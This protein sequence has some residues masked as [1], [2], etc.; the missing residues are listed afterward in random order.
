MSRT[1]GVTIAVG[2]EYEQL[3]AIAT[4]R[5]QEFT[6]CGVVI[7][8]EQ[9]FRASGLRHPSQLKFRLFDL[10]DAEQVVYFDADAFVMQRWN[11]DANRDPSMFQATRAFW[12]EPWVAR[13]GTLYGFED[14][15]VCSGVFLAQRTDHAAAFRLAERLQPASD[16][17]FGPLQRRRNR[18]QPGPAPVEDSHRLLGST[19]QLG[20]VWSRRSRRTGGRYP[21]CCFAAY[22]GARRSEILRTKV[23][24]VDL[25]AKTVTIHEKKRVRGKTT[26]R[27]VPLAPFLI[28]VLQQTHDW[29]DIDEFARLVE[30]APFTVREW[31]RL[32]RIHAE[33][34]RSGRGAHPAW[35]VSH[36][37]LERYRREGLLPIS[38]RKPA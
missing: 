4:A 28:E 9:D 12:F 32:G 19:V 22:T 8:T 13:L 17:F 38:G 14:R 16:E 31:A 10:V 21:M 26:T 23:A 5:F 36:R 2:A 11:V 15:V 27:R 6:G 33:K 20:T 24:D 30:K 37:E 25:A 34:R 7:L 18:S 35:V 1:V 3:A 29:Y